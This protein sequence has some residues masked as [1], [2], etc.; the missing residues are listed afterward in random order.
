MQETVKIP[1]GYVFQIGSGSP[2]MKQTVMFASALGGRAR[3]TG[4]PARG[5]FSSRL[6]D[7]IQC[8]S[9]LGDTWDQLDTIWQEMK[10]EFKK[11]YDDQEQG[12]R[13]FQLPAQWI[14]ESPGC[15]RDR[16]RTYVSSVGNVL[17]RERA[18]AARVLEGLYE[19]VDRNVSLDKVISVFRKI[20]PYEELPGH[21]FDFLD[22][23]NQCVRI[24][25]DFSL[26]TETKVE[27]VLYFA[28]LLAA[29]VVQEE[30]K[31]KAAQILEQ[32]TRLLCPAGMR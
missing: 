28:A 27:P 22:Y 32:A 3:E 1:A 16:V 10:E 8:L 26:Q 14:Y 13:Y 15:E 11:E 17:S 4:E 29:C 12:G 19:L 21:A 23:L 30:K 6:H 25:A 2:A 7:R 31:A 18:E 20:K 24:M 9:F 5:V